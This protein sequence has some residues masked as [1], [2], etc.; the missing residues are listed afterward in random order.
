M[1]IE[2]QEAAPIVGKRHSTIETNEVARIGHSGF[3][4]SLSTQVKDE[5]R[6]KKCGMFNAGSFLCFN[7]HHVI[8]SVL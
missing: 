8:S 2:T 3:I 1:A 6:K 7:S 4:F 5:V